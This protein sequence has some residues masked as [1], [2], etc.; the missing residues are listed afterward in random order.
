MEC[1]E[2]GVIK[3]EWADGLDLHFGNVDSQLELI[4][5]IALREGLLGDL[6]ANGT[7]QAAEEVGGD[8][9]KW[10][11]QSKGLEMSAADT[12]M[13]KSYALAFAVNPR[14]PDHLMTECLAE[15]GFTDEARA[16]IK[17]ITGDEKYAVATML[18]KRSDIVRW[19]EDCYAASDALGFCAFTT[20]SAYA[21]N[22][23]NMAQLFGQ[24][25]GVP[26]TA[27]E[28][29][30]AGRRIVTLER[31]FNAREGARREDDTLPWRMMNEPVPEGANKGLVTDQA[32]LDRLLDEYY[33]M[34]GWDPKT[35]IPKRDTLLNLGL[36]AFCEDMVMD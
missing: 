35:G 20:T 34:H 15:F 31:C 25:L 18:E 27:E 16:L 6:L 29:M 24:A 23:E 2:K 12:R 11:I 9:W 3:R 33:E 32:T 13:A 36:G 17:E 30:E 14:G 22:P 26:F 8:S 5:R 1:Y 7:K 10:A 4:R 19:H 21:V 28:L